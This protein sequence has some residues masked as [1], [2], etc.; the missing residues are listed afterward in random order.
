MGCQAE[1]LLTFDVPCQTP[2]RKFASQTVQCE[3][4][5]ESQVVYEDN[6]MQIIVPS[7]VQ[8]LEPANV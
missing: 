2:T 1:Y 8:N 5:R 7:A 4:I 3:L 6:D